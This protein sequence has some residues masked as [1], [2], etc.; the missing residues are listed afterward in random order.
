MCFG[1][2]KIPGKSWPLYRSC[3]LFTALH[4]L[5]PQSAQL[6]RLWYHGSWFLIYWVCRIY[7]D[8][9][10][11]AAGC[12]CTFLAFLFINKRGL[13]GSKDLFL[14]FLRSQSSQ[15]KLRADLR[16]RN[17]TRWVKSTEKQRSS[18]WKSHLHTHTHTSVCESSVEP[19]HTH[20]YTHTHT[21][22]LVLDMW[23]VIPC[24]CE[25]SNAIIALI[26]LT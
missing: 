10:S 19:S 6:R 9:S 21:L 1:P 2:T 4:P 16:H 17:I 14:D 11:G 25:S 3:W 20:T 5:P 12:D 23:R 22:V 15:L 18:T 8:L 24:P 7:V 13:T 26:L